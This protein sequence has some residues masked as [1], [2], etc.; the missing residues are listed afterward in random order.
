MLVQPLPDSAAELWA[1]SSGIHRRPEGIF[2]WPS[3]PATRG[4][5]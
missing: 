3:D 5:E 2:V 4:S 1:T